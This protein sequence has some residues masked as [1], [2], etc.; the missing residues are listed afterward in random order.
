MLT[1]RGEK[2]L[3]KE[4]EG[5][6]I[7]ERFCGRFE[8]RVELDREVNEEAIHAVFRNGLLTVTLPKSA[9]ATQSAKRIEIHAGGKTH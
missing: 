4:G 5:R 7:R 8:R 6:S 9:K 2:K 1:L 3:E